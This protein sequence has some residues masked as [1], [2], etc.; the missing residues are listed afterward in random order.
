MKTNTKT[1]KTKKPIRTTPFA[2]RKLTHRMFQAKTPFERVT[3][4]RPTMKK[5]GF[6]TAG[7]LAVWLTKQGY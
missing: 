1:I 5:L 3:G 6:E 7:Q 2:L 4:V